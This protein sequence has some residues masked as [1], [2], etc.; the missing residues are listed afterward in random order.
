MSLAPGGRH[1]PLLFKDIGGLAK[2]MAL[3]T[4]IVSA[5]WQDYLTG[6]ADRPIFIAPDGW[7]V[8]ADLCWGRKVRA[9]RNNGAG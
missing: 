6:C 5:C 7:T 1:A 9:P 2:L 4:M 3:W 8:A